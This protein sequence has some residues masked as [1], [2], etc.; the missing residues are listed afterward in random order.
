MATYHQ[1]GHDSK[2]LLAEDQLTLFRGAILSPVN[3]TNR[4][5]IPIIEKR[6]SDAFEFV[7]DPQLYYPEHRRGCL[8]KWDYYPDGF[9]TAD[10]TSL[11][12]WKTINRKLTKTIGTIAP[13]AACSPA[14]IPRIYD[15]K[16]Y[17][18][19]IR[20]AEDFQQNI[21][22][23][24]VEMLLTLVVN[25]SELA[26]PG[27]PEEISSILTN[28]VFRRAF[29]VIDSDIRPRNELNDA[30]AMRG[31]VRLIRH[32]TRAG[33]SI[34][35][36]YSSSDLPVWKAAGAQSC[37]TGKFFNLR[38]FTKSRFKPP[39]EGGGQVWYWF[40]ETMLAFLREGD[41]I[42]IRGEG[43]LPEAG[44]RNNPFEECILDRLDNKPGSPWLALSWRQYLW[45]FSNLE[46]H[47]SQGIINAHQLISRADNLWST[48]KRRRII[49]EEK[50]NNG[51][52][53][54][55]WQKALR[56]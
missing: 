55:L 27:R 23:I 8:C 47:L 20:L 14:F 52:W 11:P 6:P 12:F 53:L 26:N 22:G 41:L 37:A 42:R 24:N 17:E 13:K 48:L 19:I 39:A 35:V 28:H 3:M 38:R 30:E 29:L 44:N 51:S 21:A 45:W 34:I 31:A 50:E 15:N 5:M 7:F 40:E 2:N 33:I 4:E 10:R 46:D 18:F 56:E 36:G 1:M 43:L 54:P 9:D 49:M 25:M 32:L 16:Y